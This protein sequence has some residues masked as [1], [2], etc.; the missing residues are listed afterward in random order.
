MCQR[1]SPVVLLL[2][3][4]L[5]FTFL[6]GGLQFLSCPFLLG[7]LHS[8]FHGRRFNGGCRLLESLL[9]NLSIGR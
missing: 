9:C 7:T 8:K 5:L 3:K 1:L 6:L 4:S 2:D